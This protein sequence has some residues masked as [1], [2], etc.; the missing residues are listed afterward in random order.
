MPNKP[1]KIIL[2][3]GKLG[4]GGAER[5][6]VY[7]A[8]YFHAKGYNVIIAL[9]RITGNYLDDLNPDVKVVC[10]SMNIK[11]GPLTPIILTLH[12]L[13]LLFKERPDVLF[14]TL[15][16]NNKILLPIS[17]II[18]KAGTKLFV[19]VV[20]NPEKKF[21]VQ[22][23]AK[24]FI[25][26]W[27]P[28]ADLVITNS[29][30]IKR[31]MMNYFKISSSKICVINNGID[32]DAIHKKMLQNAAIPKIPST[33][34]RLVYVGRLSPQKGLN[35][36]LLTLKYLNAIKPCSLLIIGEG[37]ELSMLHDLTD[38]LGL[39]DAIHFLGQVKNPYPYIY[40]SEILILSSHYEGFPNVIL[41]AMICG[42]PVISTDAPYGPNEII[43]DGWNGFLTR[44]GD[45][46]QMA[47]KILQVLGDD[48]IRQSFICNGEKRIVKHF[49][50]EKMCERYEKAFFSWK[51]NTDEK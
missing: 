17:F 41:E 29:N 3:V 12:T 32:I 6:I 14:S 46:Q 43:K 19:G 36:L 20:N 28:K 13:W 24:I 47:D 31:S 5:R 1:K 4:G 35:D 18:K 30:G 9:S 7:L 22:L 26:K 34:G 2:F 8:N 48:N 23:K 40:S 11:M 15:F 33:H 51:E 37:S 27:Y 25:A 10:Q 38:K 50:L 44:V 45:W 39:Q 42:V 49:N 16:H 21:K